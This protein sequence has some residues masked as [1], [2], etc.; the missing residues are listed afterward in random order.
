[1]ELEKDVIIIRQK[2]IQHYFVKN[3]Y[4]NIKTMSPLLIREK[5][6]Y[7]DFLK[8][9][10]FVYRENHIMINYSYLKWIMKNGVYNNEFLIEYI[11]NVLKT[12][13]LRYDNFILHINSNHLTIMDIDKYYI[14]I[15]N[16]SLIMKETF[17]NKLDK[18][19][20]YNAP[21]IFS[22]LFSILSVFIDKLT[23]QKIS[24]VETREY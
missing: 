10:C 20:V 23:L 3:D 9:T 13:L 15:K 18:C 7:E 2:E 1:M 5:N 4:K 8:K 16:I 21:F 17:P 14:F 22:K 24:I 6:I 12:L 11:M 19:Y